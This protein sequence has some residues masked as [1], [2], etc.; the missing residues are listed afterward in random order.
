MHADEDESGQVKESRSKLLLTIG[1]GALNT[2][3]SDNASGGAKY[4]K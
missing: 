3:C 1:S 2:A 4:A